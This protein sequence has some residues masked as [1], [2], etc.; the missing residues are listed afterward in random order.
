MLAVCQPEESIAINT[1]IHAVR[2]Q[3]GCVALLT[4][5]SGW[6]VDLRVSYCKSMHPV[7]GCSE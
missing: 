7:A 4:V 5:S 3:Q 1:I 2:G 6:G